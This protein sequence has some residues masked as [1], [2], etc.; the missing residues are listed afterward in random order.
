M[1]MLVTDDREFEAL[2]ADL[3]GADA[4][5]LDT[6]FH[7]EN[8]YYP[9]VAVVQLA[10]PGEVWVVDA[11]V[12]DVSPMRRLIEGPGL[13]V[14]HA[15][16]QDLEVLDRCCGA[17]PSRIFDTQVAGGLLGY[18][19]ASLA[20]LVSTLLGRKLEKGPRMSDWFRRPLSPE[21]IEYA[22]ADV[23]HLLDLR[24]ELEA[25]LEEAGRLD[26]V[27]EECERR[28]RLRKPD[29]DI[30][31]WRLKGSR[32][33]RGT[34]RGVAQEVAAWR[35]RTAMAMDRPA[36]TVLPDEL[37]LQLA[38]R[39][40][41][42]VRDLPRS[43]LFDPRRLNAEASAELIAAANRGASLPS[44]EIRL[45]PSDDLPSHLQPVASLM[46]AWV[47]QTSRRLSIETA[48]LATSADIESFLRRDPNPR[49]MQGWRADLV[50][51]DL[52]RIASGKAGV[53][54][55]G[56]GSLVLVDR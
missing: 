28:R 11:T 43:R 46:S 36:R 22:E 18:G 12:V 30:A 5:A 24:A 2:L 33:L 45:P 27:A 19:S 49:V 40:P 29:P 23:I 32:Q 55:D 39:T 16:D 44:S 48:L 8:F 3:A 50:G 37:I 20:R 38:E 21:Q 54:Y 56:K 13:A 51:R 7:R 35:D 15:V 17:L 42:T 10:V 52:E 47:S 34:A 6:E 26:W 31:W 25:R 1:A 53:A 41:K 14:V 9:R 4:Y